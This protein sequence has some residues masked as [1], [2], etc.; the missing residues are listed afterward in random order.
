MV[1]PWPYNESNT[2]LQE[3]CWSIIQ[4]CHPNGL[5][6]SVD[7]SSRDVPNEPTT[8]CYTIKPLFDV[9]INGESLLS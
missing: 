9:T 8:D 2:S 5:N 1:C 4:N 6:D 3:L 7:G